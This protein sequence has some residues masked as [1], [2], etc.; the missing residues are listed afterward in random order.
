MIKWNEFGPLLWAFLFYCAQ[1]GDRVK[2]CEALSQAREI[3]TE[4]CGSF[5]PTKESLVDDLGI[6]AAHTSVIKSII[7]LHRQKQ[8]E[9]INLSGPSNITDNLDDVYK[10]IVTSRSVESARTLSMQATKLQLRE[11]L[12]SQD[13]VGQQLEKYLRLL[14]KTLAEN[15]LRNSLQ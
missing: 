9:L 4:A 14:E 11:L 10:K 1:C 8:Q 7:A 15:K 12:V 6:F 3:A 2:P 5:T 13:A